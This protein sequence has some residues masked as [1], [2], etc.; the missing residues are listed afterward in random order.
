MKK[1][2]SKQISLKQ[3]EIVFPITNT[4]VLYKFK[5]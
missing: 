4:Y 1:I 5:M 2:E 3:N